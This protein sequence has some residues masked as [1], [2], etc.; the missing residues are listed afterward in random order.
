[1]ALSQ[2]FWLTIV[3]C[4]SNT[5]WAVCIIIIIAMKTKR[6]PCMLFLQCSLGNMCM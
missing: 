4:V 2:K 6:W 3:F 5:I 1:M